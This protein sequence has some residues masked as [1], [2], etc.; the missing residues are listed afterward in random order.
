M[1]FLSRQQIACVLV[2]GLLFLGQDT[3]FAQGATLTNITVSNTRDDLLLYLNL[4]GAFSEKLKKAI[5]SGVPATFYFLAKLNL[6]RNMWINPDI[7]DI[8]VIH[9]I[10]FDNLKKEFIVRRSWRNNDPEVT[11]SFGEAQ[12]WMTE[13]NSLKIIPLGQLEKGQ[14]YQLRIKAEVSKQTLPFYLHYVLFFISLWDIETDWYS[15]DFIY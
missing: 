5:L 2:L 7:A 8:K 12:K 10:K 14:Q 1:G 9:T 6:V 4:E 3:T 11:K 13:V 15:I